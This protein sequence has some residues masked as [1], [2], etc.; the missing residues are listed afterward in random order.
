MYHVFVYGSLKK[1]FG[2]HHLLNDSE[3]LGEAETCDSRFE[4]VSLGGFP[5]V[6]D[7]GNDKIKGEI[8]LINQNTLTKLDRLESE[9]T[10]YSRK[11]F[12]FKFPNGN[13][14]EAFIYILL[15]DFATMNNE[16]TYQMLNKSIRTA[17]WST[18][19]KVTYI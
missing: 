16:V 14:I 10:F 13:I 12:L 6:Y 18:S 15:N 5:G 9:G 2:N 19:R 3:F 17:F 7:E 11:T 8:Y 1:G 4:M